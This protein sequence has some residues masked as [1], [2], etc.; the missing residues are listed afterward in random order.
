MLALRRDLAS[1]AH[2][3][4]RRLVAAAAAAAVVL[5]CLGLEER[6]EL[7]A[8][9]CGLWPRGALTEDDA[10]QLRRELEA[11]PAVAPATLLGGAPA[12]AARC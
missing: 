9:A 2:P 4:V 12:R 3:A 10:E 7:W 6:R 8:T 11:A 5:A 1:D